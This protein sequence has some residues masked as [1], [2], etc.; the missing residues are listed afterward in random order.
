MVI[1]SSSWLREKASKTHRFKLFNTFKPVKSLKAFEG[2]EKSSRPDILV[3][4]IVD[5]FRL[6]QCR[7]IAAGLTSSSVAGCL[8][9]YAVRC[10]GWRPAR[11]AHW[12]AR[13]A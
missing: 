4:K 1:F 11:T 13:V 9:H 5:D 12:F 2:Q 8:Y 7:G 6:E 3:E 10:G